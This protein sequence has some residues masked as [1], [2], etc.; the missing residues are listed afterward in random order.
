MTQIKKRRVDNSRKRVSNEEL[1]L[2]VDSLRTEMNQRF[3][4]INPY[5]EFLRDANMARKI[6]AYFFGFLMSLGGA[7]LLIKQIVKP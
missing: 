7:Y 6:A 1:L 2:A 4:D 5:I 3:T